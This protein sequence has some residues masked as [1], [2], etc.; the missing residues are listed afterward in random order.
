[1]VIFWC[2]YHVIYNI[3]F[4]FKHIRTYKCDNYNFPQYG[5]DVTRKG[6]RLVRS[7]VN[8][9]VRLHFQCKRTLTIQRIAVTLHKYSTQYLAL[10]TG[11]LHTGK[12]GKWS[13]S[14][15]FYNRTQVS[16]E[17]LCFHP[18][19]IR[20]E[21]TNGD[22]LYW[23]QPRNVCTFSHRDEPESISRR[24]CSVWTLDDRQK[25]RHHIVLNS[26]LAVSLNCISFIISEFR[27]PIQW[28]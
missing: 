17:M 14:S 9:L 7:H 5:Y 16:R 1:M 10:K 11:A 13:C 4:I 20:W 12:S 3:S 22:A 2:R 23:R 18:Y 24:T 19:V 6:L 21:T 27:A 8:T 15:G 28:H 26:K 25:S